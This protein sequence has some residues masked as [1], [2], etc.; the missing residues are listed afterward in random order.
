MEATEASALEKR[1]REVEIDMIDIRGE[2][3]DNGKLGNL[4][5]LVKA[6]NDELSKL[7]GR[8]WWAITVILGGLGAAAVKLV[9]IGKSYGELGTTVDNLKSQLERQQTEIFMLRQSRRFTM[10]ADAPGK[11]S[12]Q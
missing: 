4:T 5:G 3:G 11:D 12:P 8:A 10:P 1:I 7:S 2:S 9:V 6:I